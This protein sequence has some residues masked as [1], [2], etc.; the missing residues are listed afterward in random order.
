MT[1][2]TAMLQCRVTEREKAEFI[3]AVAELRKTPWG[4][5]RPPSEIL[6]DLAMRFVRETLPEYRE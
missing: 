2:R 1:V 5:S 3:R 4:R 6:R